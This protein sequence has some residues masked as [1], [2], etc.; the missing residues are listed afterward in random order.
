[1]TDERSVSPDFIYALRRATEATACAAADALSSGCRQ[2]AGK[3]ALEA[4]RDSLAELDFEAV[5]VIGHAQQGELPQF[6]RGEMVGKRGASYRADLA[7]DPMEGTAY[8]EPGQT[9]ALAVIA[10]APRDSMMDPGP[11]FYMEKFVA[12]PEARGRIDPAMPTQEKL[13]TLGRCLDKPVRELNIYV[14]EKPRHR[15]LVDEIVATGAKVSL[16]P[17]GDVAGAILAAIPESGID[18]MM[19][20]GGVPE[21]IISAAGIRALGGEFLCRIAPQLQTESM[22]VRAADLDTTH[23]LDRD[24][25]IRSG[26]I[27][28]CATGITSGLMLEGVQHEPGQYRTQ[29]MMIS[30]FTGERQV[31]TSYRP[32]TE[33]LVENV[34]ARDVA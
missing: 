17:A 20:V 3:A 12:R 22:A 1:M 15:R 26:E 6:K 24:E 34:T 23:W 8:L 28:F 31:L 30:G 33:T 9:N 11:A 4:M 25:V 19:G 10:V 2:T 27:F 29:T 13:E 5:D 32:L 14:Q 16:Y 21:G 7:A 18:A